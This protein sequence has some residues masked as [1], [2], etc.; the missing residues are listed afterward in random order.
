[1]PD[2]PAVLFVCL[3][4]ICR[5]PMAEGAFRAAAE[6]EG[7][8]V[9]ID[10]AGTGGWHQGEPPDRRARDTARRHG[11][12]ISGLKVR[13]VRAED[14]SRFTHV[15]A[16]DH[17]NLADLRRIRPAGAPAE[18]RLLADYIPGRAGEAIADPYY[19]G[20]AD[21]ERVWADVTAAAKGLVAA[22]KAR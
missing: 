13:K 18:V 6:A 15:L 2:R 1:M 16:L 19:G 9:A 14:F 20:Q 11:V 21:F 4:N 3:G 22:L 5:S 17:D 12:D 8:E 10:S 7:L